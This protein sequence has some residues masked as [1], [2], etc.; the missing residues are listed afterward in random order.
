MEVQQINWPE[1]TPE[2]AKAQKD[3]KKKTP[4]VPAYKV[5]V[6]GSVVSQASPEDSL[7]LLRKLLVDPLRKKLKENQLLKDPEVTESSEFP[8][9]FPRLIFAPAN[10]SAGGGTASGA[11]SGRRGTQQTFDEGPQEAGPFFGTQV[12]WI[13]RISDPK[14]KEEVEAAK[15]AAED[16]TV[17]KP[18]KKTTTKK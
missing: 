17:G 14:E 5:T 12:S 3:S 10:K 4:T 9:P 2:L 15:P 13:M 6:F 7:N 16:E 1:M 11:P 8:A 18:T